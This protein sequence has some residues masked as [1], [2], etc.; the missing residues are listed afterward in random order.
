MHHQRHATPIIFRWFLQTS[1][2][3][4]AAS[5]TFSH[6]NSLGGTQSWRLDE[7]RCN[8]LR[9]PQPCQRPP[10]HTTKVQKIGIEKR[11]SIENRVIQLVMPRQ[12][13]A[14]FHF[15]LKTVRTKVFGNETNAV[16]SRPAYSAYLY[17]TQTPSQLLKLTSSSLCF[18]IQS[19]HK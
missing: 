2:R 10:P 12:V 16:Q 13:D 9:N 18:T 8:S 4:L 7:E 19:L 5:N 6:R 17:I 11:R 15:P 1:A 3:G 14:A